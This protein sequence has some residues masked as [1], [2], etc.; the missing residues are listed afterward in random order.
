[1]YHPLIFYIG[2]RYT[3][4]KKRSHFVSFISLVS[5]IGIALGITVLITVLSV[6]NGFDY[7][8]REKI[9]GVARQLTITNYGNSIHDWQK[10]EK[11][12]E[13]NQEIVASAPFIM[14]QGMLTKGSRSAGIV[15]NGILP[16]REE[17]VST[18]G[19]TLT[20]GSLTS[21]SSSSFGIV[22]GK[23]LANL[24][25]AG[26][27]DKVTLII[28]KAAMTPLGMEPRFKQFTVIGIFHAGDGFGQYDAA[29][30]F[31]HLTDAGKLFGMHGGI[32]G[33]NVKLHDLYRA[34]LVS[35]QLREQLS[36]YYIADWTDQ[37]GSFF[38]AIQM[39]KTT[40]FVVLLFIIAIAVFNL[41]STMV[42]TVTDKQSD[43]AILRTLG[44]TPGTIMAIFM[45]QGGTIGLLGTLFGVLGGITLSIS[46]PDLVLL[47]E[48]ML[49]TSFISAGV[50]FIDCLPS[51]LLYG[52]VTGVA[53]LTLTMSLLATIYPAWN[54]AK[55]DP[56]TAL[57][58]E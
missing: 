2:L 33:F 1:M 27:G 6:M 17:Q 37:Y 47:L 32:T 39:E 58:Y 21:L 54:A 55:I 48:R 36:N 40:M 28:P 35:Q 9:F 56:A 10:L 44:A 42:M 25:D 34:P 8:I 20:Q 31:I 22:I 24:I 14:G 41:V 13:L 51:K 16:S 12:V 3:R 50:Y 53:L 18:I 29:T 57:R 23:G 7:E 46:A 43:I 26:L 15:V 4:A 49:H 38:K 5:I 11:R 45:I 30:T 19:D 52:D